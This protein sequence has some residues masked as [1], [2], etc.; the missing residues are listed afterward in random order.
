MSG[1]KLLKNLSR[2]IE[3]QNP[4]MSS[5]DRF[6]LM[7]DTILEPQEKANCYPQLCLQIGI[8]YP[9]S[10]IDVCAAFCAI[11]TAAQ[12][13]NKSYVG[14]QTEMI[15]K[16][17]QVPTPGIAWI[18]QPMTIMPPC[19]A[20]TPIPL[21]KYILGSCIGQGFFTCN[22]GDELADNCAG[23]YYP[24]IALNYPSINYYDYYNLINNHQKMSIAM[25]Q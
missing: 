10:P 14:L 4:N 17:I 21:K 12:S 22:P 11:N 13:Q 24:M 5:K 2:K 16:T 15:K 7:L 6:D 19:N 25:V 20:T 18:N 23:R 3:D 8:P 1:K 9:T